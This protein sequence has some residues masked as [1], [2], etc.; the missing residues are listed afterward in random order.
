MK[1]ASEV[2]WDGQQA[3]LRRAGSPPPGPGRLGGV[4]A[5]P[6]PDLSSTGHEQLEWLL[7]SSLKNVG[8]EGGPCRK[9]FRALLPE[10]VVTPSELQSCQ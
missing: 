4:S 2:N 3:A 6:V 1:A 9:P 8:A 7:H 5:T 10:A